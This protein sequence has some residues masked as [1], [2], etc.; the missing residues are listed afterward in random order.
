MNTHGIEIEFK[1][2]GIY[3]RSTY[4]PHVAEHFS[5]KKEMMDELVKKTGY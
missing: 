2:D 3:Y 1:T 4:L 5:S